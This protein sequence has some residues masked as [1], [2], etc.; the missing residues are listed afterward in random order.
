[1]IKILF[2]AKYREDF[3]EHSLDISGDG[4]RTVAD[5]LDH[6]VRNWPEQ[7][8]F[9]VDKGV[10]ISVNRE[11]SSRDRIIHGGDIVALYPPVTGG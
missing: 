11:V 5:L 7:T 1:M 9:L 4:L 2:F 3:G 8:G 6:L 10:I